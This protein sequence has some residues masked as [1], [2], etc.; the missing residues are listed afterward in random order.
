MSKKK[1]ASQTN[2]YLPLVFRTL[3]CTCPFQHMLQLRLS[4]PEQV[5]DIN[6]ED[7]R[8]FKTSA[9]TRFQ[10]YTYPLF[11]VAPCPSEQLHGI[12]VIISSYK[13][14]QLIK[15]LYVI[16]CCHGV[17]VN[18]HNWTTVPSSTVVVYPALLWQSWCYQSAIIHLSD[19]D[20][21]TWKCKICSQLHAINEII[22]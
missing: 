21:K 4:G 20:R 13:K 16:S 2:Y 6:L 5:D 11:W 17:Y 1:W 10:C 9:Q 7:S 14:G 18:R 8:H 15:V 19:G 3:A 22:K 12:V